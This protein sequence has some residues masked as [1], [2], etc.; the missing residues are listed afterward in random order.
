MFNWIKPSALAAIFALVV[1][2]PAVSSAE[3]VTGQAAIIGGDVE[4]AREMA[5]QDAMRTYAEQQVGVFVDSRT[6]VSLG[7]VIS[8]RITTE[9]RGY[10]QI[11]R[12]VT[13]KAEG[14]LFT[15]QLDLAA[16]TARIE[17]DINDVRRS[18]DMMTETDKGLQIAVSGRGVGGNVAN[19]DSINYYV[20]TK[21]QSEMEDVGFTVKL[22]D[23]V[24]RYM[25]AHHD[26]ADFNASAEV[27]AIARQ[28]RGAEDALLRGTLD[29]VDIQRSGKA[30]VAA[31]NASFELVGLD[32]NRVSSFS[33][34]FT[35]VG[36]TSSDAENKAKVLAAKAATEKLGQK[37]LRMIQTKYRGGTKQ[38]E[39]TI[40]FGNIYN[41]NAQEDYILKGLAAAKCR[42]VNSSFDGSGFYRVVITTSAYQSIHELRQAIR[43]NIPGLTT[44]DDNAAD[45][46]ATKLRF[47]F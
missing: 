17:T 28:T 18:I 37:F 9:S 12:V 4:K 45:L 15:V 8:D 31:V 35:A 34:Y 3:I 1:C 6:E 43:A 10:V 30:Y 14:D 26:M 46:G 47:T 11:K 39:T 25:S 23:D 5:R 21:M 40:F 32:D 36:A 2:L 33:D 20:L 41:R 42:V 19:L 16:D 38:L 13:E 24:R 7:M 29:T 27:R 44:L 22:N